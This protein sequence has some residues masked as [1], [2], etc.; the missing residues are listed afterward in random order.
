MSR[1]R[2]AVVALA[3]LV[4]CGPGARQG[5]S[6]DDDDSGNDAGGGGGG[7]GDGGGGGGGGGSDCSVAAQLVYVVD[8]ND[9][10]AQFDPT[11]KTFNVLGTLNCPAGTDENG[12]P[13][14][15]FS[16]AVDRNAQAYVLYND[17]HIYKV[18]TTQSS[19]PCTAT[20]WSS[21]DNLHEFGM[22]FSTDMIGGTTD[23]LFIA[24]GPDLVDGEEPS[25]STLATVNDTSWT[26]TGAGT[27][28]GWPELTGNSNA[29]LWGWFPDTNNP[30][31]EQI[32][33]TTGAAI[34]T[35]TETSLAGEP[36]AW[37]FAFYGGDYWIFLQKGL[38]T[39]TTVYQM[40]G[41]NGTI[42]S[43]TNADGLTIVGAGVST[44]APIV[45]E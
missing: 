26:A 40:V 12:D 9:K 36:T 21:Q 30:K 25:T 32:N 18:D 43:Q 7:G 45:I 4:A 14:E 33:K 17:D 3:V 15:P 23:T 24:G 39:N 19:L 35:Y 8:E 6:G 22:G 1:L 13:A 44:C 29:E 42:A 11:Q 28:N 20:S 38:E 31:V 10:L 5:Q 2:F 41:S 37:A 16:M 27:V 34:Q